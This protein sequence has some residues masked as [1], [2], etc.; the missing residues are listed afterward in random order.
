MDRLTSVVYIMKGRS[1][2]SRLGVLDL[3]DGVL[4]LRDAKSGSELFTVPVSAAAARP[5]RRKFYETNRPGFEVRGNDRWWFLVPYTI[6]VRYQRRSTRELIE[7]YHARALVPRAPGMSEEN[8]RRL[9][10]SATRHQALWAGYW[11][12]V[13]SA[14]GPTP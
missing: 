13:L 11:L 1:P 8:Y 9:T 10:G 14:A 5:A 12:A 6:P 4:S 2:F 3:S 7:R